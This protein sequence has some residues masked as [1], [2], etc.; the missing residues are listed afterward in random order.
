MSHKKFNN[1]LVA[2]PKSKVKITLKKPE[3]IGI[4][5]LDLSK[6]L[7]YDFHYDYI[8]NKYGNTFRLL[9]TD[10]YSLMYKI[11]AKDVYEDFSK[12]KEIFDFSNYSAKSKYH[13]DSKKLVAGKMKEE[14]AGTAIK[15]FVGLKSKIFSFF[16]DDFSKQ[17]TAKGVNKNVVAT[18]SHNKCKNILLNNK[19]LRHS[20]NRIQSKNH[21]IET[22]K[23]TKISLSCFDD[24][25]YIQNNEYDG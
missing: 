22:Y 8:K 11:K 2:I 13:G 6:V 4:C 1:D 25:M 16:L 23:I 9:F 24:K 19:C 15:E 14:T 21:R 3:Y 12:D 5:I 18:I 17:K 20:M 10:T 7:I